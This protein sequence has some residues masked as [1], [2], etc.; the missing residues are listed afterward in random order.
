MEFGEKMNLEKDGNWRIRF[1]ARLTAE[2]FGDLF[3]EQEDALGEKL[4]LLQDFEQ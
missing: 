4:F 3:L 2:S 1:R